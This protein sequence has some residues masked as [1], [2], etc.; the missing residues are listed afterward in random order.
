MKLS[1]IRNIRALCDDLVSSP[2]WREVVRNIADASPDFEVDGVRFIDD[3]VIEETLADEIGADT[4]TLGCFNASAIAD[5]TGWP[6]VLIEAAQ[7]GEAYAEIGDA[8][9]REQ[10]EA[11]AEIYARYDGYG[12][13]FNSWDSSEE[14]LRVNGVLFHIF[15]N[16][17]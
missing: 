16:R 6:V 7:K 5:A 15:D 10:I 9:T 8:M 4:Y 11:L 13:H 2:D 3:A 14:E 1:D 17:G 12:H